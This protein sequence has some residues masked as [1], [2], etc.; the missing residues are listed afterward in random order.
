MSQTYTNTNNGQNR[1]QI[2]GRSGEGQG[3][4]NGSGRGNRRNVGGNN[5]IAEYSFEGKMKDG[6][7]FKLTITKT[8]HR[9][10]QFKK[11]SN[12]LLV[13]CADKNYQG[14]NEVLHTGHDPVKAE[15]MPDYPDANLWS[16]T[17]QVQISTVDPDAN[18][19][20]DGLR[21]VCYQMMEQTHVTDSNIQKELLLEYERNSKNKS[22]EYSKFP[23]DKKA[24]ITILFG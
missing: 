24:L 13:L 12:A 18:A 6:P 2:S 21:P 10:S 5:L 11:I 19:E 15:F 3:G 7:I 20:D 14:F 23:A 1:N 8:G 22:K 4:P 9:P 17:H 16:T